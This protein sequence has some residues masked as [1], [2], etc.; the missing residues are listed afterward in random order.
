MK[1][2]IFLTFPPFLPNPKLESIDAIFK[3]DN[4][5]QKVRTRRNYNTGSKV[6]GIEP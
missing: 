2:I 3:D 6:A 1:S 4:I 5:L